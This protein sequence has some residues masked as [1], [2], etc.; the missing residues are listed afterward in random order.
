[1]KVGSCKW[2]AT[3]QK[4]NFFLVCETYIHRELTSTDLIPV[5]SNDK[6][7]VRTKPTTVYIGRKSNA[8]LQNYF[9]KKSYGLA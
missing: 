8:T 6:V 7:I 5:L 3:S 2:A 4:V 1:V 9:T